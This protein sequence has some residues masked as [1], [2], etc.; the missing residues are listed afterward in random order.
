MRSRRSGSERRSGL[1]S[2]GAP[3]KPHRQHPRKLDCY[4]RR[5][6]P[7]W[8]TRDWR[9][10]RRFGRRRVHPV[11]LRGRRHNS[12]KLMA[13]DRQEYERRDQVVFGHGRL[14][15]RLS[16]NSRTSSRPGPAA[17]PAGSLPRAG[18]GRL[19]RAGRP[20]QTALK[21][22][23]RSADK[24]VEPTTLEARRNGFPRPD[25]D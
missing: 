15:D 5:S 13:H 3:A 1:R 16:E 24:S 22:S 6:V 9:R 17:V 14:R 19:V 20:M 2:R 7:A 11:K 25:D 21:A 8:R 10:A 23:E 12:A 4:S 18:G